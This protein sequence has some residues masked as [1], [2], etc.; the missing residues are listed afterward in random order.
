M[1]DRKETHDTKIFA[2]RLTERMEALELTQAALSEQTG[3]QRQTISLYKKG[4]TAPASD[5]LVSLSIAL[6]CSVDW[7]LGLD[8]Y[9]RKETGRITAQEL[10]LSGEAVM[11]MVGEYS[12]SPMLNLLVRQGA[13]ARLLKALTRY[14]YACEADCTVQEAQLSFGACNRGEFPDYRQLSVMLGSAALEDRLEPETQ[15]KLFT[16]SERF[17][18][19]EETTIFAS[20]EED[21]LFLNK[22]QMREL[23]ELQISRYLQQLKE[24]LEKQAV[25]TIR[26][27]SLFSEESPA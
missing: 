16:L 15:A 22:L 19:A 17:A 18:K 14:Y 24:A 3:I 7:L 8:D 25:G 5:K 6:D 21:N 27:L 13:F 9:P 26:G 12:I 10:G 11:A 2:G 1:S 20:Q 23:Y 4:A